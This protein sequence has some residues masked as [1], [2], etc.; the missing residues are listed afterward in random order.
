MYGVEQIE[1]MD[2]KHKNTEIFVRRAKGILRKAVNKPS[3]VSNAVASGVLTILIPSPC[4]WR[5]ALGWEAHLPGSEVPCTGCDP[6]FFIL[7]LIK[8][9][10]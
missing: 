8:F 3:L 9:S 5:S 2:T 4:H 7:F 6:L 10:W 1:L